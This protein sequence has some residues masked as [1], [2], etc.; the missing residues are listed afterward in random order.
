MF[1]LEEPLNANERYLYGISTRLEILIDLVSSLVES[2]AEKN[3]VPVENNTY[4]E[5]VIEEEIEEVEDIVDYNLL[6]VAQIKMKLD[7]EE[8][9]YTSKMTKRGLIE[10]L[11]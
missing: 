5:I 1:K 7:Y 2:Y 8:I 4:E 9:D 6:T 10:L 3:E 11:K